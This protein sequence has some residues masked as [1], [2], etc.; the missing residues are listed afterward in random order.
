MCMFDAAGVQDVPI[1]RGEVARFHQQGNLGR[2]NVSN[3]Q[4]VHSDCRRCRS[5][6]RHKNKQT[7]KR[8][9]GMKA[10]NIEFDSPWALA[11]GL[12]FPSARRNTQEEVE[13]ILWSIDYRCSWIGHFQTATYRKNGRL[14][15][16]RDWD[17]IIEKGQM[18]H[19]SHGREIKL[20]FSSFSS[21]DSINTQVKVRLGKMSPAYLW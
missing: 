13:S 5:I 21:G 8:E 3:G 17:K 18:D 6:P 19:R 10:F 12:T 1:E 14:S 20:S 15:M 16:P 9:S 11:V 4:C 7:N 2:M